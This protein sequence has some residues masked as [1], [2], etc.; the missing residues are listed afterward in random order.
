MHSQ[1]LQHI[2]YSSSIN[3]FRDATAT[4][5]PSLMSA[6]QSESSSDSFIR[7]ESNVDEAAHAQ[8]SVIPNLDKGRKS[9][10][11]RH[12]ADESD[13]PFPRFHPGDKPVYLHPSKRVMLIERLM[14]NPVAT[15]WVEVAFALEDKL[16]GSALDDFNAAAR[17]M[18]T[19]KACVQDMLNSKSTPDVSDSSQIVPFI[20]EKLAKKKKLNCLGS[21]LASLLIASANNVPC[22]IFGSENHSWIQLVEGTKIDVRDNLKAANRSLKPLSIYANGKELDHFA[23]GMILIVN[24]NNLTAEEE[25]YI[26]HKFQGRLRYSWEYSKL[27]SLA[28]KLDRLDWIPDD[29]L[30][31]DRMSFGLICDRIL[32]RINE[33]CNGQ[34]ALFEM[35]G[36][37]ED[38]K[39]LYQQFNVD[40]D[41]WLD[42]KLSFL[43]MCKEFVDAFS[44]SSEYEPLYEDFVQRAADSVSTI[45][46][47]SLGKFMKSVPHFSGKRRRIERLDILK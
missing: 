8:N 1:Y 44:S 41:W 42:A 35:D 22:I 9:S 18:F 4:V 36:L 37:L 25:F 28:L 31:R 3:Y 13:F 30:Y 7:S 33:E 11:M 23:L 21:A 10:C 38:V 2:G 19:A 45:L 26:L 43:N 29:I 32:Y 17:L 47:K 14:Q 5:S 39:L 46:P 34:M 15:S 20:L 40:G 27:F 24:K 16:L 6:V 12:A